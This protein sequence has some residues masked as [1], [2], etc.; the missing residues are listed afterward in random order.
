MVR[1]L[2]ISQDHSHPLFDIT[3][4]RQ[5]EAQAQA[6][7]PKP[8]LMQRAGL[9]TARLTLAMAPHA[10]H[11]WVACGPGHNGGNGFE[12][13][14]QLSQLGKTVSLTWTESGKDGATS[15]QP[16]DASAARLRALAAGLLISP[17]P[18]ANFDVAIDALLGIGVT[19]VADRP[20]TPLMTQW[21]D[22]MH[23][24]GATVLCI[25]LP[26]GLNADTGASSFGA[27]RLGVR[28]TLSLL[29]LKP[30]LFTADGRDASGQVWLDDLG[31]AA[32]ADAKPC[33][34]LQGADILKR[35]AGLPRQHRAHA[36]HKGSFGDV[37]VLGGAPGMTGAA[38]LAASAALHAGA[39]R[40]F[41]ALVGEAHNHFLSVD[42]NLPELMFR[43]PTALDLTQQVLVCGCGGGQAVQAY[44][45]ALL[46]EAT[47]AVFDADALNA[48]AADPSLQALL[49]A[50]Q[51]RSH[52]TILTPHPLEA[53]R[54]L[55]CSTHEVQSDRRRA[56]Q[57]L[58]DRFGCV[59]VL[60]GSGS[61]I[62]EAGHIARIN[63]SGNALLASPGTGDVLAGMIAAKV[64]AGVSAGSA[65]AQAVFMHGHL[66]DHWADAYAKTKN[67]GITPEA[68]TASAL[69]RCASA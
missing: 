55:Q 66:A 67:A 45:P 63:H 57:Q 11:I 33:A 69:A 64:A 35:A 51:A 48:I 32:P 24:S 2:K 3:A 58:A 7:L 59:V 34:W 41:V 12:A 1:T 47:R 44:L 37:A 54:L 17:E 52:A 4:T 18:P 28:H 42:T 15:Q 29:T 13:A 46:A 38:L 22:L 23:S 6:G 26:T 14:L 8:S 5:I 60:K 19:L 27:A 65:A 36:S 53:A 56:A 61:V 31:V 21:L 50:R 39:G 68:L 16:P 43:H 30:G 49:A 62:A 10:Q 9:A 40:V 25:D 20:G